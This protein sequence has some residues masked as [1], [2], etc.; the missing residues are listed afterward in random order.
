MKANPDTFHVILSE[1]DQNLS[2]TV[3]DYRIF[4][5]GG[6]KLLGIIID[7]KLSFDEHVSNLCRKPSQKLHAL[8][9]IAHYMDLTK[10]KIIMNAFINS[11]FGYC[12][13]V[14]MC[15]SRKMNNKINKI[16]ERALRIMYDD[17]NSMYEELLKK[18]GSV[19]IHEKNIQMLAIE[20]YKVINGISPEIMKEI[21]LL[22]E[23]DIYHSQ[24][25][26][27]SRNIRTVNYG[28]QSLGYLGPKIWSIIPENLKQV[29]SLNEFKIK[30]KKWKPTGCPC[31]LCKNYVY[32]VGF[33]D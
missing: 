3:D 4:N 22:K 6:E 19:T 29:N 30:I 32:G 20:I 17:A 27:K 12:P 11:Q 23:K 10:R 8:S 16:Q 21:F 7:S 5:R 18:D 31:R 1:K 15:H 26:F 28:T 25:P 24:F 9:R 2:V 13:L 14:W 33:V